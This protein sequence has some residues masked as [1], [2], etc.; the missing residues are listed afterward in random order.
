MAVLGGQLCTQE[1]LLLIRKM[2]RINLRKKKVKVEV[3]VLVAQSCLAL[4]PH[5]LWPL[6]LLC[7]WDS[8]G[9]STREG[10]H[11]LLQGI[12][13]TQGSNRRLLHCR[14]ILYH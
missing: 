10:C 2:E 12:F 11:S 14:Q 13:L 5:G 9:K 4:R 3:S 1:K 7:P 6:R 8:P